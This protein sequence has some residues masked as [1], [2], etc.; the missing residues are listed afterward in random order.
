MLAAHGCGWY[1]SLEDAAEAMAGQRSRFDPAMDDE[2][3]SARIAAWE[4]AL[5]AV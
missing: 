1:A 3:R 2:A 5:L 4:K